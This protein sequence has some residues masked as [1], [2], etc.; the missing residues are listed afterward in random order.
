MIRAEQPDDYPAISEVLTTAFGRTDEARLVDLIRQSDRYLPDLALVAER[1]GAIVG[2]VLFS[3]VD[4][5]GISRV[6]VLALAPLAV[7]PDYQR[8]GIGSTLVR[9]GLE[10]A[11]RRQE[12]LVVVLG[13]AHFYQRCGFEP[14][15]DYGIE[16]PFPV[17]E[18]VYR[19]YP[20][21]GYLPEH[22]GQVIYPAAF[23]V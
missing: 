10:A 7:H 20:L 2:H 11:D 15:L 13:H 22:R 23:T 17:P 21:P 5:V 8:Q 1:E 19:V 6:P 4:L 16:C 12:P 18:E 3:Q 14:A 9:V